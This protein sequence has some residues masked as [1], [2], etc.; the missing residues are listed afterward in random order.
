MSVDNQK[1]LMRKTLSKEEADELIEEIPSINEIWVDGDKAR[2]EKYKE[3]IRSCDC[4][5]LVRI[6]KT[7]FLRRE[8]RLKAGKK[9]T[10]TDERYLRLAEDHLYSELSV[11]LEIPVDNMRS[12]ITERVENTKSL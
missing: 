5:E 3:C 9:I 1:T 12:Y 11:A 8:E 10:T 4:R 6:I 7:L 2:E